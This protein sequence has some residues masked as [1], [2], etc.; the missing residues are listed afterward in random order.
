MN[1]PELEALRGRLERQAENLHMQLDETKRQ[2]ESVHMTIELLKQ[3][4]AIGP[5]LHGLTQLEALV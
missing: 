1:H 4:A 2:L 3:D 5:D